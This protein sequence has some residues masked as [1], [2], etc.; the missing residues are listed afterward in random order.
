MTSAGPFQKSLGDLPSTSF[1]RLGPTRVR[2]EIRLLLMPT[3]DPR[4]PN[5]FPTW[6]HHPQLSEPYGSPEIPLLETTSPRQKLTL[7]H[8]SLTRPNSQNFPLKPILPYSKKP[9]RCG[10]P[11][12]SRRTSFL[13]SSRPSKLSQLDASVP[14]FRPSVR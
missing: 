10:R 9:Q 2:S 14:T 12:L 1:Y 13:I 6:R 7:I 8:A 11:N 5:S 3:T 4:K